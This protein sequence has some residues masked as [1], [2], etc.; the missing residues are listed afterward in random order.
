MLKMAL[1]HLVAYNT[2]FLHSIKQYIFVLSNSIVG[3]NVY[4]EGGMLQTIKWGVENHTI[5]ISTYN[6]Q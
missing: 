2:S 6:R 1:S 5:H 3:I 4:K